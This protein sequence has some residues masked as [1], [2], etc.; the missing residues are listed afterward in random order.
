MKGNEDGDE[1]GGNTTGREKGEKRGRTKEKSSERKKKRF[2]LCAPAIPYEIDF[3]A[4]QRSCAALPTLSFA[5][6]PLHTCPA[7]WRIYTLSTES[8]WAGTRTGAQGRFTDTGGVR[9]NRK[10]R[11]EEEESGVEEAGPVREHRKVLYRRQE[12]KNKNKTGAG[13]NVNL[14]KLK[15]T[16]AVEKE[17]RDTQRVTAGWEC[18]VGARGSSGGRGWGWKLQLEAANAA[19]TTAF[20]GDRCHSRSHFNE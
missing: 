20:P 7:G 10:E 5:P 14:D 1:K 11:R 19:S 12:K 2:C 17:I 9:V 18:K 13:R 16:A 4:S 8:D 6:P 15:W 3:R